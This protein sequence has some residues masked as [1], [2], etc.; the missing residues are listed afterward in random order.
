[1]N[2]NII[3]VYLDILAIP[4]DSDFTIDDIKNSHKTRAKIFHPDMNKVE[5]ANDKFQTLQRAYSY[6]IDNYDFIK[7]YLKNDTVDQTIKNN[8]NIKK[9]ILTISRRHQLLYI[10][11][12]MAININ[13]NKYDIV[14][15]EIKT[16]ELQCNKIN[17]EVTCSKL[18]SI[19]DLEFYNQV[20]IELGFSNWVG[21]NI[22]VNNTVKNLKI[23]ENNFTDKLRFTMNLLLFI[24]SIA[25]II[26][27]SIIG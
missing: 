26:T 6:L 25:F 1:M 5:G 17:L 24:L 27:V 22:K 15:G 9:Y 20:N 19:I 16:F 23:I 11:K 10:N 14:D 12:P 13:N 18:A 21:F 7:D 8:G 3:K 2:Y 4:I